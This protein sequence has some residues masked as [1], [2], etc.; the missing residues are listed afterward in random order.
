MSPNLKLDLSWI[1]S[2]VGQSPATH[3]AAQYATDD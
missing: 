1:S 2:A 3:D